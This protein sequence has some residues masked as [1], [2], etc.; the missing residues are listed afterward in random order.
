MNLSDST[1][2]RASYAYLPALDGFR[3]V[4]ILLV[5]LSHAGLE[6]IIPGG[7]GVLTFF[8]LSGFL[9]TR[10]IIAEIEKTGTLS[11]KRFYLRRVLRLVPP[12]LAYILVFSVVLGLLGAT[13]TTT[14]IFSGLFYFANYY[15]IFVG[16]TQHNPL[17]ILWSLSVEEHF[18][19]LFPLVI[20]LFRNHLKKILPWLGATVIV[21]LIWRTYLSNLCNTA[22][23]VLCG[24]SGQERIF[25]GTDT[26]FDSILYGAIAALALHYYNHSIRRWLINPASFGLAIA[27]LFGTLLY[28]DPFFRETLRL[29]LQAI[30]VAIIMINVL[31]S[32]FSGVERLRRFLS[33]GPCLLLGRMSYSLYLFHFG[34]LNAVYALQGTENTIEGAGGMALYVGGSLPCA[35]LSYYLIEQPM[36]GLRRRFGAHAVDSSR[37]VPSMG[38]GFSLAGGKR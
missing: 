1:P 21:V 10:Q 26:I 17:P 27:C 14:H 3:A 35:A 32:A 23:S 8:V 6:H 4:S 30:S 24:L 29:S 33:L 19:T 25:H 7:L 13:I 12:L 2:G 18:Y 9:I 38:M 22:G 20:L 37:G 34:V 28:R 11:V 5:F 15:Q 16:Y 31:F 36:L